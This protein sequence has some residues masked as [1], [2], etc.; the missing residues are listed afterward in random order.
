MTV[1]VGGVGGPSTVHVRDSQLRK[2]YGSQ[3]SVVGGCL[4]YLYSHSCA[5]TVMH[6]MNP[7][8]VLVLKLIILSPKGWHMI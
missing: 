2:S 4:V 8:D 7:R 1:K 3:S 5:K 6:Q